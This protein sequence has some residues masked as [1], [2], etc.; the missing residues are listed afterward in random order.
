MNTNDW[1]HLPNG[2]QAPRVE[3]E[4]MNAVHAEELALLQRLVEALRA[5]D[6][7][8]AGPLAEQ[9]LAHTEAHFDNEKRL[10]A[11]SGFPP[12]PVHVAEHEQVL[13]QMRSRLAEFTR[14]RSTEVLLQWLEEVWSPWFLQHVNSM[15]RVT[16]RFVRQYWEGST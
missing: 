13:Q 5:G 4:E 12:M 1:P 9:W 14:S 8:R 11:E 3:L 10:M 16:A 7:D 2:A 6:R 15:D